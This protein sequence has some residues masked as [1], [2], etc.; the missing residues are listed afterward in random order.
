MVQ[1]GHALT[2][3]ADKQLAY[4]VA[5]HKSMFFAEKDA[6]KN[7]IDYIAAVSSVRLNSE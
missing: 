5:E 4:A 7:S 1:S 3:I 2:A 6:D